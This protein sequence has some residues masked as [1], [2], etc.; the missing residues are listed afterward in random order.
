M[1]PARR[2]PPGLELEVYRDLARTFRS[3]E[4][5]TVAEE[6]LNS[7]L[8]HLS[9][10]Y[11]VIMLLGEKGHYVERI[12]R[13]GFT[14]ARHTADRFGLTRSDVEA[15]IRDM[16]PKFKTFG[17]STSDR[18]PAIEEGA[19]IGCLALFP[20]QLVY[21][22][23]GLILLAAREDRH[24]STYL[25]PEGFRLL[26]RALPDFSFAIKNALTARRMNE[27]ITKDDLTLAFNRRFFE[28]YL[29][30]E[31]D[32]ARRY[33]NPLSLIFLDLDGLRE[34]NNRFGHAMGSRTL[35]EAAARIMNAVRS[36]DK[37]IR[38]GGDE[39]C[40]V[41]PETPWEGALEVAERIRQ[42]L[43]STPFLLEETG[44]IEI[45]GSFGLSSYPAHALTKED[46]IKRADEA[47]Y[48]IK[49]QTK[50]DIQVARPLKR[51]P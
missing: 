15:L 17:P 34:V 14:P 39:F 44:G 23:A 12:F 7:L 50:N 48:R 20:I 28:D 46:L 26:E 5:K 21:D 9:A 6:I 13:A 10:D 11:G 24:E 42:R 8:N 37:V 45:T 47:M 35:Q 38:Y 2:L 4:L 51:F 22:Y 25:N 19:A 33:N 30:E 18:P 3:F 29:A 32:R 31:M 36:I 40:I 1:K 16:I 43:A 27:L 41:L 49:S